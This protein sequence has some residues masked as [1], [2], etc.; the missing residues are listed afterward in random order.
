MNSKK[1][2]TNG[3]G[4]E[5]DTWAP[6]KI[7]VITR[8]KSLKNSHGDEEALMRQL[9]G[10]L[11]LKEMLRTL[12]EVRNG[13]FSVR[14]PIDNIGL[15]GKISDVMNEIISLNERMMEEFTKAGNT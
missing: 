2:P 12:T 14:M 5:T 3:S 10:E 15:S 6:E 4:T 11:D 1:P 8:R 13:N 7:K 9:A